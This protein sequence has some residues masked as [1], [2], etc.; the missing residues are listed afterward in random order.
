[1]NVLT[2]D[3]LLCPEFIVLSYL[4]K[5]PSP[6]RVICASDGE[7]SEYSIQV[8]CIN[9]NMIMGCY[10]YGEGSRSVVGSRYSFPP[11]I[12]QKQKLTIG[13]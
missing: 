3:L 11:K 8:F 6:L 10:F 9:T 1:M 5:A 13:L 7:F 2:R 12:L 4:T